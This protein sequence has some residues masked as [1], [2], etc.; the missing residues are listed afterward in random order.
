MDFN[1]E[2]WGAIVAIVTAIVGVAALSVFFSRNSNTAGV[3]QAGSSGVATML[4]AATAP[5]TGASSSNSGGLYSTAY[6]PGS[7][8]TTAYGG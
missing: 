2:M 4:N 7:I 6:M 8:D 1:R 5:T 3:V